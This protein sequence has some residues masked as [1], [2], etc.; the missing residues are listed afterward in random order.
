MPNTFR[1]YEAEEKMLAVY[2]R[3][4]KIADRHFDKSKDQKQRFIDRYATHVQEDQ[5]TSRGEVAAVPEGLSSVDTMFSMMTA[6]DVEF[7]TKNI[8]NGT[9]EQALAAERGLNQSWRDT[10]GQVRSKKAIKDALLVDI[11]WVKVYY[12]YVEDVELRDVPEEALAAQ[13]YELREQNPGLDDDE[14]AKLLEPFTTEEVPIVIRDR[15]CVEYV[16]WDMVRY[17]SS[18]KHIEDVRWVAQYTKLPLPEVVFNPVWREFVEDRYGK[19][20]GRKMLE[21]LE[22]DS[23]VLTTLKGSYDDI[24]GL[25]SDETDDDLRVTVVELWDFET[26]LITTFPKGRDDLVLFQ[27]INPLMFNMDLEDRNPFKPLVVRDNPDSVEGIGDMRAIWHSLE[28]LDNRRRNRAEYVEGAVPKVAGPARAMTEAGK[29]ALQSQETLEYVGLEE[30]YAWSDIGVINPPP[31][32]QEQLDEEDRIK[33]AMEEAT[34]AADPMRGV[35]PSR[36]T[37]A[38]EANIVDSRGD[39][40][41]AERRSQLEQ[42]YIA[43]A[44]TILQLMQ[45]YYSRDRILR[46]TDDLGDEFLWEWNNE[47]IAIDADIEIAIT[48][49]ENLTRAERVQRAFQWM[50]LVLPMPETDREE[51]LRLVAREMGMRDEDVRKVVRS[52]EE[53]QAEASAD[54]AQAAA[55]EVSPQPFG[56]SPVGLD[57]GQAG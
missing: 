30:G 16:P 13:A 35:F 49:K 18:A 53:A 45:V 50:N 26:G 1:I 21:D 37:T 46:Y 36:R 44:R 39:M 17:D 5:V 22:G 31:F 52:H 4:L 57:I 14:L 8:G 27:R 12:D 54:Q 40:R 56:N 25:G 24:E 15:V 23:S 11:G 7:I 19:A 3:R 32:P 55:L 9:Q 42:W 47:D 41:Q 34:G 2:H 51:V 28:Q 48:P 10:K 20:K 43:I 29:K 38:T 6:L 33:Q